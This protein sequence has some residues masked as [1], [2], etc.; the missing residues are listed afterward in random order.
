MN[1]YSR[2]YQVAALDSEL[3]PEYDGFEWT[4]ALTAGQRQEMKDEAMEAI[5]AEEVAQDQRP[6]QILDANWRVAQTLMSRA[7]FAASVRPEWKVSQFWFWSPEWQAGEREAD[8]DL[9]AGRFARY[10]S[11]EAFEAALAAI[12]H[13]AEHRAHV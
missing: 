7:E 13:A 6:L 8:A 11:D 1:A 5:E 9:A 4:A 3:L 10:E 2:V 12:D